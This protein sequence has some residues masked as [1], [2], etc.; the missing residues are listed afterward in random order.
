MGKVLEQIVEIDG[1]LTSVT[2][3]SRSNLKPCN[4]WCILF[5]WL[6]DKKSGR[7]R[8][9]VKELEHILCFHVV[10]PGDLDLYPMTPK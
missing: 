8:P 1:S 5:R 10:I 4:L 2:L 6:Y 9:M 3:K 7:I